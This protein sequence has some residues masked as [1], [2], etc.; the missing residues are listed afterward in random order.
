[1]STGTAELD[2]DQSAPTL[3]AMIERVSGTPLLQGQ[4]VILTGAGGGIGRRTA[5]LLA[6]AGAQVAITDLTAE[7]LA[8]VAHDVRARGTACFAEPLDASDFQA[9]RDFHAHVTETL[10]DVDGLVNCAG[11]WQTGNFLDLGD[12]EWRKIG[13]AN[14]QTAVAG[15]RAVL[16]GMIE[17]RRGSIVNFASTSGEYGSISPAAHYAAAKGAVIALTK[18]LAREVGAYEIRVNAVSPGPIE[19]E[20]LGAATPEAKAAVGA[21]T[22]FG[23]LGRPEEIA[24]ACVFLL[25]PLAGFVTGHLLRVNGGSLL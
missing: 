25:S 4:T 5:Q 9:F 20:A 12:Q 1:M 14:L 8:P 7:S 11:L 10:G 2:G 22:L 17:R 13:L 24:G 21:R 3:A 16:P 18:S 23:R 15:C 6:A 19:T